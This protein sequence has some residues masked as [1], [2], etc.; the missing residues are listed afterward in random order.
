MCVNGTWGKV[1]GGEMNST[2]ASVVCRQLG[3]SPYGNNRMNLVAN[4][5][6]QTIV[7]QVH[8]LEVDFGQAA[9]THTLCTS[10]NVLEMKTTF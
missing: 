5:S 9:D 8:L 2:F 10:Q 3:F 6:L 1:C 4:P 7:F